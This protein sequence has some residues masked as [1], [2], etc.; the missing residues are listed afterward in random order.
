LAADWIDLAR[1]L[2][3]I[4]QAGLTYSRDPYDLE[5]YK[6][7]QAITA[8][9]VA[10]ST[11]DDPERVR[12]ILAMENGYATP[13]IDVRAAVFRHDRLLFIRER[14]ENL[15]AVPGGWADLGESPGECATREVREESGFEVRPTKVLAVWDRDKHGHPPLL[16]HTYKVFI[17]CELVGGDARE[18]LETDEPRCLRYQRVG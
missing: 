1:R 15:W 14:G 10:A 13:K 5:R 3:T 17:R 9:L 8:E 18:S 11:V 16:W 6:S 7:L 4:V 12:T 2:H